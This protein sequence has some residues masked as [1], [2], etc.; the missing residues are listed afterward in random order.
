MVMV[1]VIE[2][3]VCFSTWKRVARLRYKLDSFFLFFTPCG[4]Q[5][6]SYP[7]RVGTYAPYSG[8]VAS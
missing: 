3:V 1:L 6:L 4:M 8:S 7:T 5:D 2:G